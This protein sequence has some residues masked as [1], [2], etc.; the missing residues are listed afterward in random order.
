MEKTLV[1]NA[2]YE[3]LKVVNWQRA[4]MLL[5]QE[6]VEIVESYDRPIR[7]PNVTYLVPSVVR[8]RRYVPFQR[9][10]RPVKFSRRNVFVRDRHVCQYCGNAFEPTA[11]TFDHIVPAS[12]GGTKTFENIVTA[13]VP[14]NAK[15]ADRTPVQAGMPLRKGA[16][17]PRWCLSSSLAIE[18]G[19][20]P[21]AK[22]HKQSGVDAISMSSSVP[23]AWRP[24]LYTGD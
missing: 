5:F 24:F 1:L 13:C 4:I 10:A 23:A 12:R 2:T 22:R 14:C 20:S 7:S 18:L 8:L 19:L 16:T 11:L 21:S 15:K 3:P 17:K 9:S 6:K